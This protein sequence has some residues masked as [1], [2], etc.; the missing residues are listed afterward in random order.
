MS[1]EKVIG[2]VIFGVV[3]AFGSGGVAAHFTTDQNLIAGI[4]ILDGAFSTA[5]ALVVM[6]LFE[7]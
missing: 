7:R 1:E 3:V 5:C 6:K 4:G 2:A